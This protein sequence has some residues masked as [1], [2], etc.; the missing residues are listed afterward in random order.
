MSTSQWLLIPTTGL[1]ADLFGLGE[2][3]VELDRGSCL[4]DAYLNARVLQE[5]QG[6]GHGVQAKQ[7]AQTVE[8]LVQAV[9]LSGLPIEKVLAALSPPQSGQSGGQEPPAGGTTGQ[10]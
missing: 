1:P 9:M 8:Y 5:F 7:R 4:L 3:V 10:G 6:L 2:P